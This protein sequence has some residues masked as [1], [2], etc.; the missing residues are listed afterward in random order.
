MKISFQR[1]Y[2]VIY[3]VGLPMKALD[4]I[5]RSFHKDGS[6]PGGVVFDFEYKI[7]AENR[8]T[9]KISR[10]YLVKIL[11]EIME[12]KP[13]KKLVFLDHFEAPAEEILAEVKALVESQNQ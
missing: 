9:A 13:F 6:F 4:G 10:E 11:A 8:R 5:E 7:N 2:I 12:V 1:S 3:G